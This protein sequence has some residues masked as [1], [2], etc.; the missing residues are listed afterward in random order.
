[1]ANLCKRIEGVHSKIIEM[2]GA[3]SDLSDRFQWWTMLGA[4]LLDLLL[5]WFAVSQIG[6][7][8][9]GWPLARRRVL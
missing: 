3:V 2:K 8:V 6:M 1:M 4:V 5:V 9:H 7:I